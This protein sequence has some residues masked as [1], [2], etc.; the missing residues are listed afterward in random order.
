MVLWRMPWC[1]LPSY[2]EWNWLQWH[3]EQ[4]ACMGSGPGWITVRSWGCPHVPAATGHL[5]DLY[6]KWPAICVSAEEDTVTEQP[7]Y[8]IPRALP[9]C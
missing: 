9:T 1:P 8:A 2:P 7:P 3:E 5:G 6:G 4:G